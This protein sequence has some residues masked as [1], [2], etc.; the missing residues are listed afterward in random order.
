MLFAIDFCII[1][2]MDFCNWLVD[3]CNRLL[4]VSLDSFYVKIMYE[5]NPPKQDSFFE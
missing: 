5:I 4:S 3:F 2:L 1:C